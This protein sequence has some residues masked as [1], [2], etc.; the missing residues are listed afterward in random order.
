MGGA[1]VIVD[2]RLLGFGLRNQSIAEIE[3][4]ARVWLVAGLAVTI[5]TGLL[6]FMSEAVKCYHNQ[7]FWVLIRTLPIALLY[8]F[9]LRQRVAGRE[10]FVTSWRS[11]MLAIGSSGLWLVV[12]AA[13]RWIGFSS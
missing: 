9:A 12:A 1:L 5:V 2:L 4:G 7:S 10:G 3:R 6:L 13:G 8:T 11:R